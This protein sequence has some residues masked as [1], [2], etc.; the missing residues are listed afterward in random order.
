MV[1]AEFYFCSNGNI[2]GG[3]LTMVAAALK[4]MQIIQMTYYLLLLLQ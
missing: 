2:L 4:L 3:L 1:V